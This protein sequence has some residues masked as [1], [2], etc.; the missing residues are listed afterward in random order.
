MWSSATSGAMHL[1]HRL[2]NH[3]LHAR[4]IVRVAMQERLKARGEPVVDVCERGVVAARITVHGG[5]ERGA[6]RSTR[7]TT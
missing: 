6:H 7:L 1:E 3:V 4:A 5:V 2:L